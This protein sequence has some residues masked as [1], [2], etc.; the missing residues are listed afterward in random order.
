MTAIHHARL[1]R[2]VLIIERHD[3]TCIALS[4][5]F[6]Y[7]GHKVQCVAG[8]EAALV[9]AQGFAPDAILLSLDYGDSSGFLLCKQLRALPETASSLIVG[10]STYYTVDTPNVTDTAGFNE[11]VLKP[12]DIEWFIETLAKGSQH[13]L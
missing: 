7:Y 9:C 13:G 4:A 5:L 8:V 10:V 1:S 2:R 12:I 11:I 3:D 6:E